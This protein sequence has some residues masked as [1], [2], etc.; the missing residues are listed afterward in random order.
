ML[1]SAAPETQH[2]WS[3]RTSTGSHSGSK[4][5]S[6]SL[7]KPSIPPPQPPV[8]TI[9]DQT[10]ALSPRTLQRSVQMPCSS[11]L[12]LTD[13]QNRLIH[14]KLAALLCAETSSELDKP[15]LHR[16][17]HNGFSGLRRISYRLLFYCQHK[18]IMCQKSNR[19]SDRLVDFNL[20]LWP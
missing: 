4:S 19:S 10:P 5:R 16:F 8:S 20:V 6:L 14:W 18:I 2:L 17:P 7:I 11:L 3:S 15:G 1:N 9:Q 13:G 12:P